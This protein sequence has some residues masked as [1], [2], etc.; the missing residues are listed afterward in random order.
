MRRFLI[1]VVAVLAIIVDA[2]AQKTVSHVL[3]YESFVN[4]K[5][6]DDF[7]VKLVSSDKY[8]VR[9]NVD[10]R[11]DDYVKAYVQNGTLNLI[12]ER[13]NFPS[14]LK[15]A[16]RVKGAPAPILEVEISFP[17]IKSLEMTDNSILHKSDVIHSDEFA[18]T[19][20]DK[21]RVD[22]IFV[23]CSSA[24]VVLAKAAYAEVEARASEGLFLITS[25]T[26]KAIVKQ[27]GKSIKI[28]A[29]GSSNVKATVEVDEIDVLAAGLA[30]LTFL[31]GNAASM[32]VSAVGSS[33]LDAE[34]L[35][36]SKADVIESGTAKC[37]VNVKDTLKVNLIGNS[38]LTFK[39]KPYIDVERIVGSTLIKSDDPK[40]K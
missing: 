7:I 33:K 9:T 22:K 37:Y 25:N 32:K 30:D 10:E 1:A 40:R 4:V 34:S 3:E 36:I 26:S 28:D 19:M 17:S 14:E 23:E 11:L 16:L 24:E 20:S 5:V 13:K 15:K 6:T 21:A 39:N 8:M 31:P 29:A 12:V 2:N 27:T 18:L 38:L 35:N